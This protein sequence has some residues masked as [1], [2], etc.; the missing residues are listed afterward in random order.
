MAGFYF[1][2]KICY[3]RIMDTS[4]YDIARYADAVHVVRHAV[5][6]YGDRPDE[7]YRKI[8]A[9]LVSRLDGALTFEII[10]SYATAHPE[11]DELTHR[12]PAVIRNGIHDTNELLYPH[13]SMQPNREAAERFLRHERTQAH[14]ALAALRS[15]ESLSGLI[16]Y[17][18]QPQSAHDFLPAPSLPNANET[19]GCPAAALGR[20]KQPSKEFVDFTIL[21]GSVLIAALDH[22]DRFHK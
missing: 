11:W 14:L 22:H 1:L 20:D 12:V 4:R 19:I 2:S 15:E 10:S 5:E 17:I 9:P 7:T 6:Q 13:L 18:K 8:G 21:S 16:R 3:N